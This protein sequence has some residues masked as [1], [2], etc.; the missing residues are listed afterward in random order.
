M[1]NKD[2]NQIPEWILLNNQIVDE[3]GNMKD[4]NKDKEA[5]R[6]YFLNHVN[7]KMKFFHSLEEKLDYLIEH[8]YYEREFIE[9]YEFEDIKKLFK[10]AYAAKFRFPTYMGAFKFYNDYALRSR[11]ADRVFLERYE[12]RLCIVALYHAKGDIKMAEFLL[13]RLIAQDFTPA[14]PTLLNTGRKHRGEFVSCFLLEV[15]DSLNGIARAQEFAMQ[16]SN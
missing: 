9:Q 16:L 1:D 10:R 13:D 7:N 4:P 15:A 2:M 3:K 6:S 8:E 5:A 12:D 14:T 11:D